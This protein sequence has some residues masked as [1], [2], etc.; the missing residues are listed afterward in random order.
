M[1]DERLADQ[2]TPLPV[3]PNQYHLHRSTPAFPPH[4]PS[5]HTCL[6]CTPPHLPSLWP[7][8]QVYKALRH[9][10]QP[11]A[12]KVLAAGSDARQLALSDFRREVAILKACRDAN[13]VQFVVRAR[14]R[15]CM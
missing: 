13:I 15:V 6:P 4:L 3:P 5:L 7:E 11:V 2:S 1:V 9:G 8:V 14:V 10:V 12:V